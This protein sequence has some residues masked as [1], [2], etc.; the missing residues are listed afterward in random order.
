[1]HRGMHGTAVAGRTRNELMPR[2]TSEE[3]RQKNN[4]QPCPHRPAEKH[5]NVKGLPAGSPAAS[6]QRRSSASAQRSAQ[7][8]AQRSAAHLCRVAVLSSARRHHH[9]A[10]PPHR[11]LDQIHQA[12]SHLAVRHSRHSRRNRQQGDSS[13]QERSGSRLLAHSTLPTQQPCATEAARCPRELSVLLINHAARLPICR[14]HP[15]Q[16]LQVAAGS[17]VQATPAKPHH[18][19]PQAC[20]TAAL[21]PQRCPK[22]PVPG[23]GPEDVLQGPAQ[24]QPAAPGTSLV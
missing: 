10:R 9:G 19:C 2:Q 7:R 4:F 8:T 15:K 1:M 6:N 13:R 21:S 18:G 3:G 22:G 24:A 16:L 11:R 17:T 20:S 23:S 14:P 5:N 12:L